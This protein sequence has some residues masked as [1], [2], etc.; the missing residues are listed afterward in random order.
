[1]NWPSEQAF[2]Q[3]FVQQGH[4]EV[5]RVARE[6]EELKRQGLKPNVRGW[7]RRQKLNRPAWPQS[8][9]DQSRPGHDIRHIVRNATLKNA[10]EREYA[11]QRQGGGEIQAFNVMRDL[12]RQI[13][14]SEFHVHSSEWMAA[15]YNKAY[16]NPGNL[17]PG[18]GAINRVIG[19]T[20][21]NI[22]AIGQRLVAS[23]DFANEATI[24][25][26][27][28][29]VFNIVS[30]SR[31]QMLRQAQKM[32]PG[33]AT[34][35][36]AGFND[37]TNSINA[38]LKNMEIE[39]TASS[40]DANAIASEGGT[41]EV[42]ERTVGVP[43]ALIGRELIDIAANF[44]FDLPDQALESPQMEALIET[45]TA[46]SNYQGGNPQVLGEILKRFINMKHILASQAN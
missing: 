11:F 39:L 27:L 18:A 43:V 15:I 24:S 26:P 19:L 29:E 7:T 32:S 3:N 28:T 41:A 34:N 45:E 17:F 6:K 13:G 2:I 40:S 31:E 25:G 22:L 38:Y 16:L 21:D 30:S 10:I 42:W 12:G 4:N 35:F 1:V 9:K 33:Q 44:G 20:A 8:Y 23:Q 37:F 36:L 5:A 46:L 14:I